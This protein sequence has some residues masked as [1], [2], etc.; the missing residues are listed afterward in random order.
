MVTKDKRGLV[1]L[2]ELY[3]TK[4]KF[5]L[6]KEGLASIRSTRLATISVGEC[7]RFWVNS[8]NYSASIIIDVGLT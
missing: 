7:S 2:V 4:G 3:P 6:D 8:I 1:R 5:E